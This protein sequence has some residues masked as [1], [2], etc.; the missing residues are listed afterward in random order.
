[1][2]KQ[3]YFAAHNKNGCTDIQ[4]TAH[5]IKQKNVLQLFRNNQIF[6][7]LLVLIYFLFFGANIW[8]YANDLTIFQNIPS[9][10]SGALSGWLEHPFFNKIGFSLIVLIQ[11]LILNFILN[12]FKLTK[13]F[14]FVPAVCFILFHFTYQDIDSLSPLVIANTFLIWSLYSLFKSYE[15]RVSLGT[16]FNI[17]FGIALACLFYH[18]Y[19]VFFI[20]ALLSLLIIRSFDLQ[21]FIL[22]I[23]GYITPFFFMGTYHFVNDNLSNWWSNEIAIH[24]QTLA[25]FYPMNMQFYLLIALLIVPFILAASNIQGIYFKTTAREKKY[26]HVL[27]LMPVI[28]LLSILFQNNL[29]SVHYVLFA[30][31]MSCL[32]SI[33][34]LSYKSLIAAEIIHLVVFMLILG[35]Q[36][37]A[38]FFQ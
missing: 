36:Y 21:E 20:W 10:L 18:S 25:V 13:K 11:A 32:F 34:L 35:I 31:P 28:G 17:G 22:L 24:Y 3:Y 6:T 16:V 29:Y 2:F 27:F 30:I 8:F 9:T 1:M 4:V 33:A 26:I 23:L 14:S 19:F 15:K 7:A 38:F 5:C 12:E 37:Q